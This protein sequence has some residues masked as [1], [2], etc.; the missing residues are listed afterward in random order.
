[1]NPVSNDG[2]CGTLEN[3]KTAEADPGFAQGLRGP[4]GLGVSI[5]KLIKRILTQSGLQGALFR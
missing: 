4:R 1:M 5:P 2:L 3:G